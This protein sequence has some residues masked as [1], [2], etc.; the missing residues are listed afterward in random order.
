MAG[1]MFGPAQRRQ[2]QQKM[3]EQSGNVYEKKGP[4]WKTRDE[5][6]IL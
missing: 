3:N 1:T 4:L 6:G 5:A 2:E